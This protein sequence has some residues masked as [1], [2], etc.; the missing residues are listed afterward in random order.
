MA[1][2]GKDAG[3]LVRGDDGY[4]YFISGSELQKYRLTKAQSDCV[5]NELMKK[6]PAVKVLVMAPGE[7]IA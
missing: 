5:L 7:T 6:L 3:I 4:L 2:R 1:N